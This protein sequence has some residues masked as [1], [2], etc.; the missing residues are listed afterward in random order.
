MRAMRS[1]VEVTVQTVIRAAPAHP[2]GRPWGYLA[3]GGPRPGS[4]RSWPGWL[5]PQAADQ[6]CHPHRRA[7]RSARL[8]GPAAPCDQTTHRLWLWRRSQRFP[9]V[10]GSLGSITLRSPHVSLERLA[11]WRAQDSILRPSGT[12]LSWDHSLGPNPNN[13]GAGL[14]LVRIRSSPSPP[15]ELHV[16][17]VRRKETF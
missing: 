17:R 12:P 10:R 1:T 9:K 5:R 8:P 4:S 3:T 13:L 14:C 6:G 7:G 11:A 15:S 2:Q 16:A